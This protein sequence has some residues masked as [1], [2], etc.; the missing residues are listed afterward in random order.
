MPAIRH[1]KRAAPRHLRGAR[2]AQTLLLEVRRSRPVESRGRQ[3][4]LQLRLRSFVGR[5]AGRFVEKPHVEGFSWLKQSRGRYHTKP[6]LS[7]WVPLIC[8]PPSSAISEIWLLS[9]EIFRCLLEWT[10]MDSNSPSRALK[11]RASCWPGSAWSSS[12]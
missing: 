11:W 2:K 10:L 4:D 8:E 12:F 7:L 6:V 5:M 3:L 9:S 1:R